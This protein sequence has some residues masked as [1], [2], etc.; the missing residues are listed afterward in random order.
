MSNDI[1]VVRRRRYLESWKQD[2]EFTEEGEGQ[3]PLPVDAWSEAGYRAAI[4]RHGA[5]SYARIALDELGLEP[6]YPNSP[7]TY[8]FNPADPDG[9][10]IRPDAIS[11]TP[12]ACCGVSYNG[13][14]V[15]VKARPMSGIVRADKTP[16]RDTRQIRAQRAIAKSQGKAHVLILT[17]DSPS[18]FYPEFEGDVSESTILHRD[19][20]TK[21]WS[22][23]AT[24]GSATWRPIELSRAK[25][26]VGTK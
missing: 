5:E 17:S 25:E 12:F 13:L 23:W 1:I 8:P 20:S 10:Q 26:L 19:F 4:N 11:S 21:A 18:L 15:E 14:I 7:V 9:P 3:E 6:N 24:D 2:Q 22:L 16:V